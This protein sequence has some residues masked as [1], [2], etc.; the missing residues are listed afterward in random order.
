MKGERYFFN[1]TYSYIGLR[2]IFIKEGFKIQ[3]IFLGLPDYGVPQE[4]V[5]VNDKIEVD[6]KREFIKQGAWEKIIWK[7]IDK[8]GLTKFLCNNYIWI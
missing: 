3:K 1:R 4:I 6:K 5:D 8:A 2:K 7:S